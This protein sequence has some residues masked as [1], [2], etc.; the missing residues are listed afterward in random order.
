MLPQ[1]PRI[2]LAARQTRA[3]DAALLSGTD[4]DGLAIFHVAHRIRLGVL[5]RDERYDEVDLCGIGDFLVLGH[6]VCQ[7]ILVDGEEVVPLF[8]RDAENIL[9]FLF[10]AH[11]VSIDLHDVVVALLLRFQNL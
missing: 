11:V 10:G 2:G 9:V 8:K 3:V 1:V 7:Q 6:D 5:Q 4:A